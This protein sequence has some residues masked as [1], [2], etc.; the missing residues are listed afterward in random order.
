MNR[1]WDEERRQNVWASRFRDGNRQGEVKFDPVKYVDD[2]L[3][4]YMTTKEASEEG[5]ETAPGSATVRR[6]PLEVTRAVSLTPWPGDM[7][8]NAASPG[9]QAKAAKGRDEESRQKNP[10]PYVVEMHATRYQFG[11]A[12]T[13]ERLR[14]KDRAAKAIRAI[15]S[16]RTVAGN[17]SRFLFDF[18][19]ETIVLRVTDDPA[20]RLLYCFETEDAGRTVTAPRLLKRVE[21][22]DILAQELIIGVSD[23]TTPL[24]SVLKQKKI[25]VLGVKAA[26][27]KAC[28]LIDNKAKLRKGLAVLSLHVAVPI[29]CFRKGMVREYLETEPL[30]PPATCYGMLLSLVGETDRGRHV[31]ARVTSGILGETETSVVL[32]T[33]WRVKKTPLGSQGNTRPDFQELLTGASPDQPFVNLVLHV[34]SREERDQA[35]TLEGRVMIALDRAQRHRVRRWGA[36]SLGESTHMVDSISIADPEHLR[37]AGFG[38]QRYFSRTTTARCRSPCGSTTLAPPARAML[39]AISFGSARRF[40]RE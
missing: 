1:S 19:P 13:P 3:L 5:E 10:V 16:L 6:S 36:V 7:T 2:D 30:P 29:A 11:L 9:A 32:R 22:K 37:Q 28:D 4:G 23:D 26:I 38:S 40:L 25:P 21:L 39:S 18:S 35:T 12:L 31:G 27:D 20:P 8:F 14:D 33:V 34:C 15:A 24:A 17:H